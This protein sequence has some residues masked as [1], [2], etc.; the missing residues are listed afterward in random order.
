MKKNQSLEYITTKILEDLTDEFESYKPDLIVIQGDTSTAFSSA[1]CA[2]YKK[3]PIA[4]VEAGL[5]TSN[6][7]S[8]YPEE[9]N[10][11]LISQISSMHFAPTIKAKEN[12]ILAGIT[13]GIYVTGNTVIDALKICVNHKRNLP[14]DQ[15]R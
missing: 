6:L 9:A 14:F 10:R 5:R 7:F 2:F 15:K 8:P 13:N 4:H 11:R 1:L 12:L 3:I